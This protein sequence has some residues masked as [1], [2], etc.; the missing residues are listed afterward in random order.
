MGK[1][2]GSQEDQFYSAWWKD[3]QELT[4]LKLK[5]SNDFSVVLSTNLSAREF[6]G[7][8]SDAYW[9]IMLLPGKSTWNDLCLTC[10][11]LP[12]DASSHRLLFLRNVPW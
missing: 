11:K 1:Q 9:G 3:N 4:S 8:L 6:S 12:N 10:L 7:D 5:G 2:P